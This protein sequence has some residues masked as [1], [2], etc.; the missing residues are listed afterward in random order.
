MS[1]FRTSSNVP[2]SHCLVETAR[3]EEVGFVIK[4]D[5][6]HE[7]CVSFQ[8]LDR[9]ALKIWINEDKRLGWRQILQG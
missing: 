2:Y 9:R 1:R 6:K 5:T 3:S 8:N 4:V 7:V